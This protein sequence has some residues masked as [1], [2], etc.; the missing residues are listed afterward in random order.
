[1][2]SPSAKKAAEA[3]DKTIA[4]EQGREPRSL[5]QEDFSAYESRVNPQPEQITDALYVEQ[6]DTDLYRSKTLWQPS[7]ARGVFGGQ[8]IGQSMTA[9]SNTVREGLSLHSLHCYFLLAGKRDIPIIYYVTRVR[10]GGS[11]LT[12]LVEAKQQGRTIFILMCS[13]QKPEPDQPTFAIELPRAE[14]S[15]RISPSSQQSEAV[16]ESRFARSATPDSIIAALPAPLDCPLNEERYIRVLKERGDQ[17]P[18]T[19]KKIL[20]GWIRD[21]QLSPVEIRDA[22]PGMYDENGLPNPGAEQAFW[23]RSRHSIQGGESA[24]KAALAYASDFYLLSSV[25]KALG[26]SPNISMMASLDHSM[27]FYESN[28]SANEWI[29]F[30]MQTQAASNG[31]GVVLGRMYREDGTLL[32]VVSQEGLVRERRSKD[33]KL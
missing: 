11:Y 2:S 33:A 18:E 17:I 19:I 3:S 29:L 27:H 30:L 12:R 21:R 15:D 24:A 9:A 26:N 7:R 1:M 31:R 32:A 20:Q 14:E 23:M 13:Y 16:G 25:P 6:I 28:F 4:Q 10:D 8:V 5:S 22:H